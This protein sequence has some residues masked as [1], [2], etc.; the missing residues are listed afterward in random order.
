MRKR[1][2][3]GASWPAAYDTCPECGQPDDC[4]DCNHQPLSED[5]VLQMGGR[6]ATHPEPDGTRYLGNGLYGATQGW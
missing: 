2:R 1:D 6:P 4:G 3:F 5:A